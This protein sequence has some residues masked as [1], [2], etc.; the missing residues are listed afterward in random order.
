MPR[1]TE[2]EQIRKFATGDAV[3]PA[4]QGKGFAE[5]AILSLIGLT[6]SLFLLG[7][8]IGPDALQLMISQ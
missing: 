8:G 7:Q 5:I 2:T 3:K 4:R 1:A 6:V